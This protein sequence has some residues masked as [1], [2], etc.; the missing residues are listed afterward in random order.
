MNHIIV[1]AFTTV[2]GV[3]ED[4]D[5][6]GGTANGGWAFRHGP[7]AVAG[8]KFE[9]GSRLDTGALVFGRRTWQEF[10][11]LWPQRSDAFSIRMNAAQKCVASRTLT[12]LS[13]WNNSALIA[14]ELTS[15]AQRLR[16]ERDVIVIGSGSITHALR[17]HDLVDE[18]RLLVFPTVLG[19][20]RRLFDG[21]GPGGELRLI[22]VEQR[23][24]AALV[25]YRR[26]GQ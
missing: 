12:D 18:Y 11:K 22:S 24:P 16:R 25:C 7:E 23:G 2:D 26:A 1:V 4:P 3:V 13:A 9:L 21:P 17:A 15:E 14:G 20:G 6:S 10:T 19:T 5:G 8:D